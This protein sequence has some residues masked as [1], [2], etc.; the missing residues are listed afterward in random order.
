V[1]IADVRSACYP[2]QKVIIQMVCGSAV[3]DKIVAFGK[4]K[5]IKDD[6]LDMPVS[7]I[8]TRDDGFLAIS[9]PCP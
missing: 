9:V 4:F 7:H 8:Y 2:E 1:T 5:D 6:V 3:A